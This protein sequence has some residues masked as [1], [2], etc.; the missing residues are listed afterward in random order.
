MTQLNWKTHLISLF[1][2]LSFV[3]CDLSDPCDEGMDY[4]YGVCHPTP[5]T[6]TTT[7]T[8]GAGG[9][10]GEAPDST[11]GDGDEPDEPADPDAPNW[12]AECASITD[13]TGGLVCDNVDTF[14]CIALCGAGDAFDGRCPE[15]LACERFGAFSVCAPP[16]SGDM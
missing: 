10:S 14:T 4:E 8:G 7:A 11:G 3:G 15:T 13:C 16:G 9:D 2:A 12:S 5:T 6:T 1:A